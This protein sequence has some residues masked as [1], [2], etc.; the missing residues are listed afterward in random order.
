MIILDEADNHLFDELCKETKAQI[1]KNKGIIGLTATTFRNEEGTEAKYLK[2]HEFALLKSGIPDTT[3]EKSPEAITMEEFFS[4]TGNRAKIV[5]CK[6]GTEDDVVEC[7]NFNLDIQINCKTIKTLRALKE[8][9]LFIITE[10]ELVRGVDY[11]SVDGGGIN[12]LIAHS[13]PTTRE[14]KQL[15]GR[16]GRYGEPCSRYY[17]NSLSKETLVN[18]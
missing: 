3:E 16:V 15:L 6:K 12:L 14:L 10:L 13:L 17:V 1:P 18:E 11:R 9:Q 4:G 5:Y 2:K 7:A 8:Q